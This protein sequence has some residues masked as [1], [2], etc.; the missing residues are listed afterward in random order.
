M[1]IYLRLASSTLQESH[2]HKL[3]TLLSWPTGRPDKYSHWPE[4]EHALIYMRMSLVNIWL[5]LI[6]VHGRDS[7]TLAQANASVMPWD[8]GLKLMPTSD[9]RP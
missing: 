1:Q 6:A 5:P 8:T 2:L 3:K 9:A 7:C 4:Y